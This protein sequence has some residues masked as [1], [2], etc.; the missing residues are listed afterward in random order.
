MEMAPPGDDRIH[1]DPRDGGI[2]TIAPLEREIHG[3]SLRAMKA[4]VTAV[5]RHIRVIAQATAPLGFSTFERGHGE[6]G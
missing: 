6:R 5:D 4:T 1:Q 2:W 3:E